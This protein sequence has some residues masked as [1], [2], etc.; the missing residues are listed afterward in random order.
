MAWRFTLSHSLPTRPSLVQ[1]RKLAK[2]LRPSHASLS[3]AQL[4]IAN[5]FGFPSWPKLKLSVEQDNLRAAIDAVEP[6][7]VTSILLENPRLAKLT[8]ADGN[9]PL[10]LAAERNAP[11]IVEILVQAGAS[12][13]STYGQSAHSPLSWAITVGSFRAADKLAELGSKIDLFCAGGLGSLRLVKG[14]WPS[15]K[16][17]SSPSST[18]SSRTDEA[19]NRLPRPPVNPVDQ[20]SDALYMA[21]RH[22]RYDVAEWLLA[23]G[24]DPNWRGYMGATCLAWA[25]FS[26]DPKLCALLRA[27]GG[28][29]ELADYAFRATPAVFAM[30]TYASWGSFNDRLQE[31]LEANPELINMHGGFGSLLNAAAYAGNIS[32][33]RILTDFGANWDETNLMG[34]TPLDLARHQ[35]HEEFVKLYSEPENRKPVPRAPRIPERPAPITTELVQSFVIAGHGDLKLLKELLEQEPSLINASHD[36][37]GGDFESAIEG[38]GHMGRA[39]IALFLIDNGARPNIFTMAMLGHLHSVRSEI[40]SF[41]ALRTALGP[42]GIPLFRHAEL[43]G[44]RAKEVLAYLTSRD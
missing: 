6:K 22:G 40:E 17:V 34:A 20:V 9:G 32:T 10:H 27:R 8:F 19:G 2:E 44:D 12:L 26:G 30:M 28:S 23:H 35:G 41:P 3:A 15:G 18:G 11:D 21:C 29:D 4:A 16:L 37:G 36:W 31:R 14:F 1:L 33:A 42:H 13:N 7:R 38:A 39:D 5:E 43:G 24:A 25:E